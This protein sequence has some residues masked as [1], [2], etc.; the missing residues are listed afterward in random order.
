MVVLVAIV[1]GTLLVHSIWGC[2]LVF[3]VVQ[4]AEWLCG[5]IFIGAISIA[6]VRVLIEASFI[7]NLFI[8]L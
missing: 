4:I 7:L 5:A 1:D 2:E 8:I 6:S 3:M